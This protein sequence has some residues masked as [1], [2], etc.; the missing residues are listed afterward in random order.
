MGRPKKKIIQKYNYYDAEGKRRCKTFTAYGDKEL[1]LKVAEFEMTLPKEGVPSMTILAAVNAYIDGKA[2]VLSPSTVRSYKG[3]VSARIENDKIASLYTRSLTLQDVQ[4]WINREVMDNLSPK[5]VK[6]HTALLRSATKPYTFFDWD[7]LTLPQPKKYQGHTPNDDEIKTLIEYTRKQSDP[8][9]YRAIL[10][11]TF[12]PLRRSEVCAITD[13]D[14]KGNDITIDKAVVRSDTGAWITKSTKTM[15]STRTITYPDFVIKELK[16][17]TG[18]IVQCNPDALARR[19][20]RAVKFAKLP[21]IRFH[22]LR[23]YGASIMMYLVSQHTIES[24]GGWSTNSPVLRKIYQNTLK[25]KE[26]EETEKI[27]EYFKKFE[28]KAEAN[29][30]KTTV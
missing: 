29:T 2:P 21:H 20:E 28:A 13:K 8:T 7:K 1:A 16:G 9:L 5:T 11:T 18:R 26:R 6:D 19:F 10:L 15:D 12:G 3:I 24:R 14:I 4:D 22:D 23:H 27:N 17:I 25:D 30:S